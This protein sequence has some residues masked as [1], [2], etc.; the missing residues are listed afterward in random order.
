MAELA[1][2]WAQFTTSP[3]MTSPVTAKPCALR[4]ANE[5]LAANPTIEIVLDIH[6]DGLED[7]PDVIPK[8][9]LT[10]RTF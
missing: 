2:L 7:K 10:V 1:S 9:G 3:S 8:P 5:L 4:K 6:R